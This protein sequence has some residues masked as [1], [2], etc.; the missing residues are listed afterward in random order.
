MASLQN[1]ANYVKFVRGTRTAWEALKSQGEIY[2][3][4]LYFIYEAQGASTGVLYLGTTQIGG[5]DGEQPTPV[6]LADLSDVDI[7]N[8]EQND[9]LVYNGT[10]WVNSSIEEIINL[11]L[12]VFELDDLD[13]ISL[14]G[15]KAAATGTIPQKNEDG[16]ISWIKVNE[17]AEIAEIKKQIEEETISETEVKT[18][19]TEEIAKVDHL[20]YEK[21]ESL[22]DALASLETNKIYLVPAGD[23]E[24][25]KY[26]EY[27][28][29]DGELEPV[30]AWSVDLDNYVT[31][32]NFDKKVGELN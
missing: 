19:I 26:D 5:T 12:N 13:E 6:N 15:F 9:I 17:I 23:I 3:D 18:L 10:Q 27:M 32:E 20:S 4:T 2:N 11:D 25:N 31:T 1:T 8:R 24:D 29:I 14:K 28:V 16:S 30:G 7:L 22:D 21:V